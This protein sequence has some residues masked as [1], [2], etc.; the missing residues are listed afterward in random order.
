MDLKDHFSRN[1]LELFSRPYTKK[2]SSSGLKKTLT[3]FLIDIPEK[4]KKK[5]LIHLSFLNNSN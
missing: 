5:K 3:I 1:V 4:K 2:I